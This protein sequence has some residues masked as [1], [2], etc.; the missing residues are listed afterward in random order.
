MMWPFRPKK[1]AESDD[2]EQLLRQRI[3]LLNGTITELLAINAIAQLLF[4]E[5]ENPL[6][7]ITLRVNSLGGRISSGMAVIDAILSL[8]VPVRTSAATQ[9]HGVALAIV[10]AGHKSERSLGSN[11]EYSF[12]HVRL[13]G[14]AQSNDDLCRSQKLMIETFTKLT[15]QILEYVNQQMLLDRIFK[16]SDAIAFGLADRIDGE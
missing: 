9:A 15:G 7:P 4:L 12:G 2:V 1:P 5:N 11:A 6:L 16:P 13:V 10:A 14:H 8:K 3:V